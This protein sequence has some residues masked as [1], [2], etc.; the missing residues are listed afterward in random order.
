MKKAT[1]KAIKRGMKYRRVK[2]IIK[3][4]KPAFKGP[5]DMPYFIYKGCG[6]TGGDG[7]FLSYQRDIG[8][9]LGSSKLIRKS[10]NSCG[11]RPSC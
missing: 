3:G 4:Q 8:A 10:L 11:L 9:P 1:Y 7:V 5:A 2:I 6:W